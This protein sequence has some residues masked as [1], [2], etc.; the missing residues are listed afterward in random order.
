[1]SSDSGSDLPSVT[2][3]KK[4]KKVKKKMPWDD[5]DNLR[6]QEVCDSC[7]DNEDDTQANKDGSDDDQDGKGTARSNKEDDE[8]IANTSA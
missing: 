7:T 5:P 4:R 3:I 6:N 2:V 1:M 8:A